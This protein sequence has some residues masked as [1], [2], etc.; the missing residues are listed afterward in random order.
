MKATATTSLTH[1]LI[2][3]GVNLGEFHE[4]EKWQGLTKLMT[5][6]GDVVICQLPPVGVLDGMFDSK[7]MKPKEI[8]VISMSPCLQAKLPAPEES[9]PTRILNQYAEKFAAIVD[10]T[11]LDE[12]KAI[13][14]EA[15]V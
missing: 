13:A 5:A 4:I 15:L 12:A 8:Q 14:R 9:V 11:S 7:K 1:T 2:V 6:G 3:G 10:S